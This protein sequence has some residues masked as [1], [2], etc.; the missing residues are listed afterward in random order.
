M[1]RVIVLTIEGLG[2]NLVG[3]YGGAVAPTKHW[4]KLAACS[5]VFDQYWADSLTT[6]HQLDS[7][8]LGT[9]FAQRAQH[10][11]ASVDDANK[12]GL[13]RAL[14]VTDSHAAA[15]GIAL[16]VFADVM[17]VDDAVHDET[18]CAMLTENCDTDV[19][20]DEACE[21]PES[22]QTTQF[23]HLIETA[24]GRWS[25]DSDNFPILWIHS[26]GL[27]AKWDAPYEYRCIM[28]DEGDPEPP[29]FTQ[30]PELLVTDQTDPDEVFGLAC[31][32][33]GQAI[34]MDEAWQLIEGALGELHWN[35]DCLQVLCGV[36]GYALG[37]HGYVGPATKLYAESAHLPLIVR[38]GNRLPLGCRIH[39]MT[40][41]LHLQ[42][43]IQAWVEGDS[44]QAGAP[45]AFLNTIEQWQSNSLPPAMQIAFAT[46]GAQEMLM[47]PA[48]SGRW[49]RD[50]QGEEVFE[51]Y[52]MPDDRWQQNEVSQRALHMVE[53][54]TNLRQ[55]W[56]EVCVQES[57]DWTEPLLQECI[58][59]IR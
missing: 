18:R 27:L 4:N 54:L 32:A 49:S 25:T 1:R 10:E 43:L 14:L 46:E 28:C 40:Q 55:K 56:R 13:D 22:M 48:W 53:E 19:E 59:P 9:H 11:F 41:P 47:V 42:D 57:G 16:D 37:E 3:C 52:A 20:P 36:S 12:L 38:P 7:L 17:L 44:D 8:W 33:G 5:V 6:E 26:R 39:A 30:P 23:A 51:L 29:R 21:E 58:A 45:D 15:N 35:D 2:T 31:A 34:A 24:I 50:D